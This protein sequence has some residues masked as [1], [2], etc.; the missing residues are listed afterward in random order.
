MNSK[1]TIP[2]IIAISV[3]DTAA[4]TYSI[5]FDQEPQVLQKV[6]PEIIY[7]EKETKIF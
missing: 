3:I 1:I 6:T 2:I 5:S 7:V 4:I